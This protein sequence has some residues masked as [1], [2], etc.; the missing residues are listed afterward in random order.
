MRISI[1][2]F[3]PVREAAGAVRE[4]VDIEPPAHAREL[5]ASLAKQRGGKLAAL[6]LGEDGKLSP[7]VLIAV[8]DRQDSVENPVEL[9]DGD[10]IVI[11]PPVAGVRAFRS[12]KPVSPMKNGRFTNGRC[13]FRALAKRGSES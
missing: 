10:E 7:S 3:G 9:T 6:L 11:I 12:W 8:G 4:L 1:E 2:Y 13:G 5:I